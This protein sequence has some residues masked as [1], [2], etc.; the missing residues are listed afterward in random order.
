MPVWPRRARLLIGLTVVVV[1]LGAG[2]WA[3]LPW[4]E[5]RSAPGLYPNVSGT[6]KEF[7]SKRVV[8]IVHEPIPG[9]MDE[10]MTHPFFAESP[11]LL[12]GLAPGDRIRFTVRERKD[13]PSGE[14]DGLVVVK[15]A[16]RR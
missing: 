8:V 9:L 5:P 10:T 14:P 6:V 4:R 3:T 2:L 16:K 7:W 11:E 13:D 12:A 15:I 1:G